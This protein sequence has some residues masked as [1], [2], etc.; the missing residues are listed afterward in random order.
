MK[1]IFLC[2]LTFLVISTA[3]GQEIRTK[4]NGN[5]ILEDIPSI[6]QSIKDDLVKFQ[7]V[8][9]ASFRG[10]HNENEGLYISTRFGNVSQLHFVQE[11]G[12]ARNQITYFQEPIGSVSVHPTN[13]SIIFTMDKGGTENAQ[14]YLLDP[15]NASAKLLSDGESRNGGPLWSSDGSQIAFQSTKRN[16]RSN[17]IWIMNVNNPEEN[18]VVLE[19]PDGTW[20]GASD[21][22]EN[23][24][25]ILVQ[26]YISITN[27][28]IYFCLLY[29]SPSPR[30]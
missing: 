26:N 15:S 29:T 9:S 28:K 20:W 21:W 2:L 6:P 19:S 25:M 16:G 8:R 12:S 7:N 10:F 23:S 22:T 14:I 1:N 13:Q 5:L 4:N 11:P 30:D 27:S 17:D 18:Q 24:K 3:F